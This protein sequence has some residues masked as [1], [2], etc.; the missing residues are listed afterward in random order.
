MRLA[1]ELLVVHAMRSSFVVLGL[2]VAGLSIGC[3]SGTGSTG[4]TG[5][6]AGNG[7]GGLAGANGGAGGGVGGSGAAGAGGVAGT[8]GAVGAGGAAGATGAGGAAGVAGAAGGGAGGKGGIGGQAGGGAGV[9]GGGG[10]ARGGAGGGAGMAGVGGKA[11]GGGAGSTSHGECTQA[12]DCALHDDCCT[13]ASVP[14]DDLGAT[15]NIACVAD[16][17]ASRGITSADVTCVAGRC[18]LARSCNPSTVTCKVATPSCAAG[19]LPIVSGLCYTGGCL[20]AAQCSDVASCE[21]C[22]SAGL[23][24]VTDQV[25]G[26]PS[27]HCVTVPSA[28]SGGPTCQCLGVCTGAFQCSD[29]SS[30]TPV[31]DCPT[32]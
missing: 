14:K 26:G 23:A 32:C 10:S 30:T 31:C 3:G 11:G 18:V 22:T 21:V 2:W 6:H 27:Y 8:G 24:C 15:C 5:G 7:A 16:L 13:C 4:G 12:S 17:C 9:G 28:C 1:R 19:S 25:L 29:P 20:P